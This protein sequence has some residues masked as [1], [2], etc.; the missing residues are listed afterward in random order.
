MRCHEQTC[1]LDT[2]DLRVSVTHRMTFSHSPPYVK[3]R[4]A[5]KF[6]R[7]MLIMSASAEQLTLDHLA[8][9]RKQSYLEEPRTKEKTTTALKL[10]VELGLTKAGM[11]VFEYMTGTSSEQQQLEKELYG[12]L[13]MWRC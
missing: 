3:T 11:A 1:C 4:H 8:Q 10:T 9:I 13:D 7:K 12:L 2:N 5:R 6:V